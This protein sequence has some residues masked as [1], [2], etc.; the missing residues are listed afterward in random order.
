MMSAI[1]E[2]WL[3]PFKNDQEAAVMIMWWPSGPH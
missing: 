1:K 2:K 3:V